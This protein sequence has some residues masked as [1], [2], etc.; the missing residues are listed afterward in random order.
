MKT[1]NLKSVLPLLLMVVAITSAFAFQ[2][3]GK[4]TS[5]VAEIGW[6]DHPLPCQIEETCE[7]LGGEICTIMDGTVERQVKGKY[8]PSDFTCDKTL[9]RTPN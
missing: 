5:A 1:M 6:V 2:N 4:A 3:E 9:T 7:N 8:N